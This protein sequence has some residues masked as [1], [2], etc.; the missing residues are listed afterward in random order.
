[1]KKL[2]L[3]FAAFIGFAGAACAAQ[4]TGPKQSPLKITSIYQSDSSAVYIAFNPESMPNCY[5]NRGGYLWKSHPNFDQ[6]YAQI[7]T[8][9]AT[10]GTPGHVLFDTV[11]P[12]AGQW[13]DCNIR[14]LYLF[15]E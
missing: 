2:L 1:M 4:A 8:I 10:G 7:L 11:N 5:A 9:M 6:V 15:P 13:S 3:I 14:G 12:G